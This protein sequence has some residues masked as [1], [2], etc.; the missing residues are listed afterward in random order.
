[1][2]QRL[3]G[4]AS[5]ELITHSGLRAL[6]GIAAYYRIAAD[7]AHLVKELALSDDE[8]GDRDLVRAAK[9]IGLKA[10]I[11]DDPSAERLAGAPV[12]AILR[13]KTGGYC[14]LGGETASENFRIVDPVTRVAREM[15]RRRIA[16]RNRADPASSSRGIFAARDQSAHLRLPVV[17]ALAVALP[18]AARPCAR[19]PPSSCR[20][21][22]SSRRC[23]SRWSSTRC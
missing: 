5:G 12:P 11:V 22:P 23:S 14:I 21:S 17:R 18:Q 1:M 3:L 4:I 20:S 13:L 19:S 16:G 8:A 7:P 9:M 15:S 2:N 6:C 10:R